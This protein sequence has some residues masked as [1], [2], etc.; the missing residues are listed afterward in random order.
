MTRDME[1]LYEERLTRYTTALRNE[2][3]DRVPVRPF[4][5]EFVG[6]YAG[7]TCQEI[8]QDYNK[9]FEAVRRC[10][11]DF[12][13]DAIVGN[14]VYV[15]T[16]MTQAIGLEYYAAPGVEIS[17]DTAFQYIE[18]SEEGAYMLAEEYDALIE[19]PTGFLYDTWLPRVSKDIAAPGEP[20]SYRH[21]LALVKGGMAMLQYFGALGQQNAQLRAECGMPPAIGGIMKAPLDILG[22]KLRGYLGLT[23][24]LLTIPEKVLEACEAL[25]PHLAHVALTSSDPE[26]KVPISFWM[27]RGGVPFVKQEHFDSIYW[28]TTKQMIEIIAKEGVQVLFYGEGDWTPHLETFAELPDKSIVFHLDRTD[29]AEANRVLGKKFCLSGGMLNA[30]LAYGTKDEVKARCRELIDT[31]AGDGGYCMDASA[32]IQ[33]EARVENVRIMTEFTQEYGVY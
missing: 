32:I 4:A 19:D 6:L 18:P 21:N 1:A 9:A 8:T 5:A 25:A 31:C 11:A 13:W 16:A 24:D 26:K 2:K 29:P 27:H 3:P 10:A 15:W 20:V 12:E 28:P 17:A 7:Y 23:N 22:D 14:M 33:N 30:T